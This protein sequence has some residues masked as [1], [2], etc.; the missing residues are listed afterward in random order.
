MTSRA[1]ALTESAG[2]KTD[3]KQTSVAATVVADLLQFLERRGVSA[4]DAVRASGIQQS[5]PPAS[6]DRVP[7]NQVEM[8]WQYSI[9]RTGDH[10][11]GL[12][13]TEEYSPGTLDI[14]GFVVLSCRTVGEVLDRVARY[15]PILND[16]MRLS[17]VREG[18]RAYVEFT[19]VDAADN[20]LA[21]D[22]Q[23]ALDTVWGG[24]AR[25]LGRLTARPL[26]ASEVWFRHDVLS[27]HDAR[28]YERVLRAPV[29]FNAVADRFYIAA[30]HLDEP[31]LSANPGLLAAFEQH[32]DA[33]LARLDKQG[34]K[35][36]QVAQVLARKLKGSV[37]P[38]NEIARELAMS[39]RNLQ[40]ALQNDGTSFQRLLD[41]VR[42]DLAISHLANDANSTG[43]VGFLLGFSEPSAFHRAFRR[44]TG[45]APSSYRKASRAP[46]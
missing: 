6:D 22:S 17:L 21:R 30:A 25:E 9:E 16:G 14:L 20:Y 42:R 32:A 46:T 11:I 7:G 38:L 35:S 40:R 31:I 1:N 27:D 5:F 34:S 10:L 19:V 29:K 45:Q 3:L 12:H 8:L 18:Q 2:V 37:P 26:T 4:R 24:M 23:Q 39:E 15:A 36:H 43:Q 44:W 13:T 33:M 41:E 28:E